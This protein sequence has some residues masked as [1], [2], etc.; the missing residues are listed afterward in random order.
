[1]VNNLLKNLKDREPNLWLMVNEESR[2]LKYDAKTSTLVFSGEYETHVHIVIKGLNGI[3]RHH[4][5]SS[6][7]VTHPG[8][9]K[10]SIHDSRYFPYHHGFKSYY[11]SHLVKNHITEDDFLYVKNTYLSQYNVESIRISDD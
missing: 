5:L 11:D 7:V 6:T 10:L 8:R 1:M 9:S 3:Y 4:Q 2:V